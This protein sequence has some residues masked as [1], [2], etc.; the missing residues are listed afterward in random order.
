MTKGRRIA[1]QSYSSGADNSPPPDVLRRILREKSG[2][3]VD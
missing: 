2:L 3:R 1:V